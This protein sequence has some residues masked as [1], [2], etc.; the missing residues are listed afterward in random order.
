MTKLQYFLLEP[1]TRTLALVTPSI[2]KFLFA[3]QFTAKT[4]AIEDQLLYCL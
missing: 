4:Q 2:R 3:C 1:V